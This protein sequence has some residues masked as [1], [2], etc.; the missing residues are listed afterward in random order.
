MLVGVFATVVAVS[1]DSIYGLFYLCSDLI[2]VILFPQ[3]VSI[4]RIFICILSSVHI[5]TYEILKY[6]SYIVFVDVF[7]SIEMY[8]FVLFIFGYRCV[9]STTNL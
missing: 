2:Y 3:L 1:V 5:T 6:F 7:N 4:Y 9:S 8:K